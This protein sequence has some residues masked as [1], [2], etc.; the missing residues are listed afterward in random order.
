MGG[1]VTKE[2]MLIDA[3]WRMDRA[4]ASALILDTSV[5]LNYADKQGRTALMIACEQSRLEPRMV[6]VVNMLVNTKSVDVNKQD[7]N[8][9]TALFYA[10]NYDILEEVVCEIIQRPE[11]NI[12][13]ANREG[14]T[15]LM[16]CNKPGICIKMLMR[17]EINIHQE[18]ALGQTAIMVNLVHLPI[19]IIDSEWEVNKVDKLGNTALI[20][21]C[22]YLDDNKVTEYVRKMLMNPI[23]NVNIANKKGET[24]LIV[25][26]MY[27]HYNV[28]SMLLDN[29][30]IEINTVNCIGQTPLMI[31]CHPRIYKTE[32]S[33]VVSKILS[34]ADVNVDQVDQ[35]GNTALINL[36]DVCN[37]GFD[38]QNNIIQGLMNKILDKSTAS[39]NQINY[40]G[41]TALILACENKYYSVATRILALSGI[42]FKQVNKKGFTAFR[43]VQNMK[44]S[45]TNKDNIIMKLTEL[46][47]R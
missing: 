10:C 16:I 8:G 21:I 12:N 30:S 1:I 5:D 6:S 3:C 36:C 13:H 33:D 23:I 40:E 27:C 37:C 24:A 9:N 7:R 4:R 45:R 17:Q 44:C 26:C 34:R 41:N 19:K 31:L 14:N 28:V 46:Y 35:N 39:V 32:R 38:V 18:N 22:R 2:S 20:N 11:L 29:A 15:A 42:N 47:R 25:A 43:Y